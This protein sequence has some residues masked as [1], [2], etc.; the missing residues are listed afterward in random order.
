MAMEWSESLVS[1]CREM[2]RRPSLSGQEKEMAD[3]VEQ[4]MIELGFD[5]VERDHYGNVSGRIVLGSGGRRILFEG[6]MD[7]VD[8]VDPS[9]WTHDPFGAEVVDG[10]IY[11]RATSDMKGNLAASIMAAALIKKE[12]ADLNG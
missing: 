5:S 3:F 1:L 6:H 2:I 8:I 10:R 4:R 7:H 12:K 11:G 9:K